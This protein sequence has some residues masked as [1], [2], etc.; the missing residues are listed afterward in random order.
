MPLGTDRFDERVQVGSSMIL[1]NETGFHDV[2]G[3]NLLPCTASPASR[4]GRYVE[5]SLRTGVIIA[6]C[7]KWKRT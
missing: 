4:H 2:K 3:Q 1:A 6:S 7:G 5:T